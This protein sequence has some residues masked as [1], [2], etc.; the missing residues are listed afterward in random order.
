MADAEKQT[1]ILRHG[2]LYNAHVRFECKCGCVFSTSDMS[3]DI[4]DTHDGSESVRYISYCPECD[5]FCY[6]DKRRKRNA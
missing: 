2:V 5:A 4:I 6:V 3:V 1:T